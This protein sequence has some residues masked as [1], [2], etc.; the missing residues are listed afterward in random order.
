MRMVKKDAEKTVGEFLDIPIQDIIVEERIRSV[1]DKE[2]TA[3]KESIVQFGVLEPIIV[4]KNGTNF[5]LLCG[6]RRLEASRQ[7]GLLTIPARVLDRQLSDHENLELELME[8]LQRQG[9]NPIDEAKGYQKYFKNRLGIDLND[10]INNLIAYG[11]KDDRVQKDVVEAIS[12]IIKLSDKSSKTIQNY[13]KLLKLP[14]EIQKAIEKGYISFS[15]GVVLTS[16]LD[17]PMLK[18]YFHECTESKVSR[19]ALIKK[20]ENHSK[21]HSKITK[22]Y[23]KYC[24]G[25]DNILKGVKKDSDH[26]ELGQAEMIKA[27]FERACTIVKSMISKAEFADNTRRYISSS[28]S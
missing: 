6:G 20:F 12:T 22:P 10:S 3:F 27:Q 28:K 13:L 24:N 1:I 21:P 5:K 15:L 26:I 2:E 16:H 19:M 25:I 23:M 8:N 14:P 7:L 18:T 17:H 4:V 11:W 9:L